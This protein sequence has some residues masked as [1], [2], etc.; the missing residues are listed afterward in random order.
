MDLIL[1]QKD[2]AKKLGT[3]GSSIVNWETDKTT[4][5]LIYMPRIMDFLGYWPYNPKVKT[6]GQR[7]KRAREFRGLT[8]RQIGQFVHIDPTTLAHWER[9]ERQPNKEL[10]LNL[11]RFFSTWLDYS[12]QFAHSLSK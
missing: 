12:N 3:T 1:L 8:L 5:T 6:L 2:I 4:P 9:D 10:L 7:I 11:D